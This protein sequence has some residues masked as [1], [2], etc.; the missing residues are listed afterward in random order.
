[1]TLNS[2]E[3]LKEIVKS[4]MYATML[5][6]PKNKNWK[7]HHEGTFADY[8][9]MKAGDSIYFFVKRKIY[10]VGKLKNVGEDCK[11][12]NYPGADKPVTPS[13]RIDD[14]ALCG[15]GSRAKS[16]R[17]VCFFEPSPNFYE[18]GIDM[19]DALSSNPAA[20]KIIRAF[21]KRSFIKI[22]DEENL[23][24]RSVVLRRGLSD[25][26]SIKYE[27]YGISRASAKISENKEDYKFKL[28]EFIKPT[29]NKNGSIR[30]EMALEASIIHQL[31]NKDK[32]AISVFGEWDYLSHQVVASPF[33]PID[34]MDKIDLFGYSF[35]KNEGSIIQK[36]LV[37]E[38]K[39]D[40]IGVE[41]VMQV[42]KYVDWVRSEYAGGDYSMI[43]AFLVGYKFKVEVKDR[44]SELCQR[45]YIQ[46]V[47]PIVPATWSAL[48][49][50]QY[51]YNDDKNKLDFVL[52][53]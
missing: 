41:D 39:R 48:K 46:G 8:C 24:L 25:M 27:A 11:Y 23:A 43:Q 10:G 1:M 29:I 52:L 3:S 18:S 6:A 33:K 49:L 35:I 2:L 16:M 37:A 45:K 42:M 26:R 19:D 31:T 12:L 53:E 32:G 22:S 40:T 7:A 17:F 15:A 14:I 28:D 47:R 38:L 9:S 20:F 34:Y 5:S 21:W 4:G 50:V 44:L 13:K 30:H 36:Y 51:K